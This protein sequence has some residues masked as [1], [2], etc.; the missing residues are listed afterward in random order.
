MSTYFFQ[1]CWPFAKATSHTLIDSTVVSACKL[2][3]VREKE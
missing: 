1:V 3:L 2:E